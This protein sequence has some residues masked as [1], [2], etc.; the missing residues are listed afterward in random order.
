MDHDEQFAIPGK[1]IVK[2]HL[3]DAAAAPGRVLPAVSIAFLRDSHRN[4]MTGVTC[5][6]RR[7]VVPVEAQV[8]GHIRESSG[9]NPCSSCWHSKA[10][11]LLATLSYRLN[12]PVPKKSLRLPAVESAG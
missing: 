4:S 9:K 5:M 12:P 8:H 7:R 1:G 11:C 3:C 2:T 10:R 6:A